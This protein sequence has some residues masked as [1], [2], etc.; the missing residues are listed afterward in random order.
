M[1]KELNII[2]AMKMPV[3]T[4]FMAN[5]MK[6]KICTSSGLKCIKVECTNKYEEII[7]NETW[8]NAKFIP[9]QKPVSFMEA[10]QSKNKIKVDIYGCRIINAGNVEIEVVKRKLNNYMDLN[11]IFD[12]IDNN[13]FSEDIREI[14]TNGKWY[15][16][17]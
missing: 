9:I 17:E 11:D 12:I 3:E 5:G 16:E 8:I 13:F 6:V 2:E 7:P 1:S 15:I 10:V 4:E 14:I